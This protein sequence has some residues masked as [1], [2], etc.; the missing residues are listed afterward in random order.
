[1]GAPELARARELVRRSGT[2]GTKVVVWSHAFRDGYVARVLRQL[3]YRVSITTRDPRDASGAVRSSVQLVHVG[4]GWDYP[5]P[6]A[7]ITTLFG[8]RSNF[9]FA[10][11]DR[12][13]DST[14]DV[15]ARQAD[16]LH[17]SDPAQS[18]AIWRK[19][20]RELT[21]RAPWVFL[22]NPLNQDVV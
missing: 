8:C 10:A 9:A 13:C 5:S 17:A 19:L 3:G 15:A 16:R 6:A 11:G 14:I 7:I 2:R 20:D 12:F 4:W 18:N 21:D 1:A 22:V